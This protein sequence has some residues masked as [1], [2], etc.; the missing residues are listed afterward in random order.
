MKKYSYYPGC[1]LHT[2]AKEYDMSVR[3]VFSALG[4]E[5]IEIEDWNCCGAL[6]VGIPLLAYALNARNLALAER[7]GFDLVVPC[8]ACFYNLARTDHALRDEELRRRIG[9]N[10]AR[11]IK[12]RHVLD[13]LA[14]DLLDE[15]KMRV[16]RE[17]S[18]R[19]VPYYGCLT[20]R[21]SDFGFDDPN[22]PE[23]MD[24]LLSALGADVPKFPSKAKCCGGPI[25]MTAE[26]VPLKMAG[27]ILEEAK[28]V[29]ADAI[30]VAC[31]LCHLMLDAKQP[32][33]EEA[34]GKEFKVPIL[35]FTQLVGLALDIKP[36]KL[37]LHKNV[38]PAREVVEKVLRQARRTLSVGRAAA[39]SKKRERLRDS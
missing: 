35:Y 7:A 5:L 20:V 25:L 16:K 11:R 36:R 32:D 1:T 21:P 34:L 17:L 28:R 3:A 6:E 19:V 14:N 39:C 4:V 13:V 31:P 24:R 22:H 33:I 15:I 38:V 37:G 27:Q 29:G 9:T 8:S 10:Y 12:V 30:S 26:E 23:S 2:S 18:M